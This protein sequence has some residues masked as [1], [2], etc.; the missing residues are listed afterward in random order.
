MKLGPRLTS[1]TKINSKWITDPNI[2]AIPTKFLEET[3]G[4][5]LYNLGLGF[6][7]RTPELAIRGEEKITMDFIK[8]KDFVL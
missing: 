2:T 1:Y 8:I 4:A 5:N 7:D 6:L 3:I